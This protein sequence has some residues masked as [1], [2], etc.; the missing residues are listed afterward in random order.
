MKTK[1]EIVDRLYKAG[2]I[3]LE[4]VLI[5]CEENKELITLRE[6]LINSTKPQPVNTPYVQPYMPLSYPP[7]PWTTTCST[8]NPKGEE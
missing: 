1:N 5:L 7:L 3:S 2:H 4:E 6:R 8:S